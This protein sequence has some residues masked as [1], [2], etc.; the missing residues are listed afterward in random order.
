MRKV[1]ICRPNNGA[2][3]LVPRFV[4]QTLPK[5]REPHRPKLRHETGT[6]QRTAP[7]RQKKS[8]SRHCVR[9]TRMAMLYFR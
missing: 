2:P 4:Q 1:F 5:S 9:R 7:R 8:K 6:Q 3:E